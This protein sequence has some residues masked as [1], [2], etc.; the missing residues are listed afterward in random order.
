VVFGLIS[1]H[2]VSSFICSSNGWIDS[3]SAI[4]ISAWASGIEE[5]SMQRRAS[6][7]PLCFLAL[8]LHAQIQTVGDVSFAV[9]DGWS[10]QQGADVGGMVMKS[11]QNYWVIAVYTPM[12]ASG[13][14]TTDLQVAWKRIVLAGPDYQGYPLQPFTDIT[15]TVGYPGKRADA[16]SLNR[17]TYTRLYVLEAGK[18]FIPVAAVSNDGMVLNSLE[19]LANAVLGSIRLAPMRASPIK[20]SLTLADLVGDWQNGLANSINFYNGSTGAYQGTSN[21]FTGAS[22][23]IAANGTFTYKMSGVISNQSANDT[24]VGIVELGG[25]FVTFRGRNHVVRYRFLNL[26]Q[27]IDGSTVLTFL[28]PADDPST[29]NFIRDGEMWSRKK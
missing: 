9:P 21:S 22:Y 3:V 7:L 28:P 10:Y 8:T 11:G 17:A 2:N 18:S 20:T 5:A 25:P 4:P 12:V 23:H 6:F 15:H 24:D 1:E 26:Q 14:A 16:S 13:D 19:Y 27:A 29:I